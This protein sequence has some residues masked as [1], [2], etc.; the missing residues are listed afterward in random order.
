M[1]CLIHFIRND[2]RIKIIVMF[3]L[4][5]SKK[6]Q[7][8]GLFSCIYS[9]FQSFFLPHSP[10]RE[11]CSTCPHHIPTPLPICYLSSIL[12]H[13]CGTLCR[14]ISLCP[15][16]TPPVYLLLPNPFFIPVSGQITLSCHNQH[17]SRDTLNL[18]LQDT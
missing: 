6:G 5:L 1:C 8:S 4:P 2:N 17:D 12:T 9:M 7:E 13:N 16:L 14:S 3:F 18:P 10:S 15:P 11:Q